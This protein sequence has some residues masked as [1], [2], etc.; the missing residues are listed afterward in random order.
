MIEL[1]FHREL[2]VGFALD[3]TAKLYAAHG[4]IA[5]AEEP[6][7]WIVRVTAASGGVDPWTLARELANYALGLTIE[8]RGGS[9]P[10]APTSEEK[11]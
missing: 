11:P 3:E 2:Y 7:Y 1:R 4:T 8:R 5:L 9:R 6:S 10:A